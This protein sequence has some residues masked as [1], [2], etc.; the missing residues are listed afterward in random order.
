MSVQG[1]LSV[2]DSCEKLCDKC[3]E[4]HERYNREFEQKTVAT[5]LTVLR[6]RGYAIIPDAT[7]PSPE[8]VN[9]VAKE[10]GLSYDTARE[11]I[12]TILE[13]GPK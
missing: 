12:L 13:L 6:S 7:T 4:S 10:I 8:W 5:A 1:C 9:A 2:L 11:T 3:A